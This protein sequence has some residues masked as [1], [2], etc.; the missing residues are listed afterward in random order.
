MAAGATATYYAPTSNSLGTTWTQPGF[1]DSSWSS[2]LTGLGYGVVPGFAATLYKANITVSTVAL[3]QSVVSTPSEQTSATSETES[4]LNF[5]DTGGDGHFNHDNAFPGM[6]V[7]EGLSN[8]V[9]QATGT[10]TVTASQAGYYT[11]GANTDDGFTLTITGASFSNG[12]NTTTCSGNTMAFSGTRAATDSLA[13]TYL[14]AGSYP[15]NL[16]Y[17]QGG[18]DAEMEFY[19]AKESTSTGVTTF[20]STNSHLV[21]DTADGG[22][23]VSSP[24]FRGQ[25]VER[26][27][28]LRR[29]PDERLLRRAGGDHRGRA[30][31]RSIRGSPSAR[32]TWRR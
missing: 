13:T 12:V 28:A 16:V 18:G 19:A 31:R 4:V 1:N 23:A 11:F 6:T 26:R 21:G 8:Y 2:G 29:D 32:P 20:D 22:L 24:S 17:Y 30:A 14:A 10:L 25:S 3:A 7:G 9:L 15:V 27:A 5:L